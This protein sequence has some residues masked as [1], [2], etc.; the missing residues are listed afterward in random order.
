MSTMNPVVLISCPNLPYFLGTFDTAHF[1]NWWRSAP[2]PDPLQY[3][4]KGMHIYGRSHLCI[5][6]RADGLWALYRSKNYGIDWQRV[7]LAAAGE[8]I[9]DIVLVTYGRAIMN[10]STGFYETVNAGTS[11]TKVADLPA[12]P[13]APAFYNIGGGDVLVCTDGRYI[14]RSAD[15]A[16]HWTQV[17][18]MQQIQ[19]PSAIYYSGTH[20]YTGPSLP[21]ITGANGRVLAAC[22]PFLIISEDAGLTWAYKLHWCQY[23]KNYA[24]FYP[25]RSVVYDRLWPHSNVPKFL[26]NQILVSSVDGPTGGDACFLVKYTD[27]YPVAGE[28]ELFSR[29]FKTFS[30]T[31][32]GYGYQKN[33]FFQYLFQQYISPQEGSQICAYDVPVT[34]AAYNDSLVF[35]AQTRADPASGQPIPSLKYSTDGGATWL[36]VD[37]ESVQIG[38]SDGSPVSGGSMLDDNFARNT[39][40]GPPCNNAGSWHYEELYR[41]QCL[42]Y[43]LELFLEQRK[44]VIETRQERIDALVSADHDKE[45]STDALVEAE[46]PV[47]QQID[48][49]LEI[50]RPKEYHVTSFLEGIASNEQLLDSNV[51]ASHTKNMQADACLWDNIETAYTLTSMLKKKRSAGY[52]CDTIIV[53]YKLMERLSDIERKSVQ[54]LDIDVPDIPYLPYNSRE[55]SV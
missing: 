36:D 12:A 44:P 51:A 31:Y 10:T 45:Q 15:I 40:S 29:V 22:G 2:F 46:I 3:I 33:W 5:A 25:P 23:N 49:T 47:R 1:R 26:I 35:S 21:A 18:D 6:Q 19:F 16:R 55:E 34:G 30:A 7:W 52:F 37:L 53:V 39:W 4:K 48:G 17:C 41:R 13:N 43:E 28:T 24:S 32:A 8:M 11:W 9:Y 38:N 50:V 27:Q 14:W 42:S 54:L 20:K